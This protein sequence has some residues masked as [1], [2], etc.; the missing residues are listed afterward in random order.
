M[1][2]HQQIVR[3]DSEHVSDLGSDDAARV[4][5]V[6]DTAIMNSDAVI[7]SDYGKG[8]VTPGAVAY[9]ISLARAKEIPVLVDP[10]GLDYEKYRGATV[11][12]P[13]KKEALDVYQLK[14]PGDGDVGN[15]GIFLQTEFGVRHVVVTLGP[16]GMALFDGPGEP[17]L[18]P[19]SARNVFDVTGAGDTVIAVLAT[20]MACGVSLYEGAQLANLAA[21]K[22]VETV[23]TT[24]ITAEALTE[25]LD[26]YAQTEPFSV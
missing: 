2:G 17:V 12:T 20:A 15:A 11:L 4:C 16:D 25:I 5:S 23:G 21:G 13:N 19:A 8:V 24:A 6:L 18:L 9:L 26:D 1:A 14:A 10:K 7:V 3:I 22:V